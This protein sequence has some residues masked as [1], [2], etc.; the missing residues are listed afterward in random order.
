MISSHL[1]NYFSVDTNYVLKKLS[2]LAFPYTH[3]DWSVQYQSQQDP[4]PLPPRQSINTPDLY[5]PGESVGGRYL[6]ENCLEKRVLYQE[7]GQGVQ[8]V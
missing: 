2:L 7:P 3:T 5:I 1:K 8:R 4:V 6:R